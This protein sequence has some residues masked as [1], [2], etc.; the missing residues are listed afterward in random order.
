[1]SGSSGIQ[2]QFFPAHVEGLDTRVWQA[3]GT[4][5]KMAGVVFTRRG[6]VRKTPGIV[7]LTDWGDSSLP[8]GATAIDSMASFYRH[9]ALELVFAYGDKLGVLQGEAV[10]A[11]DSGRTTASRLRDGVR[12][13]QVG[14][15]LIITN[16]RDPNV[17]W[18]GRDLTP[19]G[20]GS[21]PE[22]PVAYLGESAVGG[23]FTNLSWKQGDDD[24]EVEYR[25]TWVNDH[26]QESEASPASNTID[27]SEAT[28]SYRYT[29]L[30]T[31]DTETPSDDVIESNYYRSVDGG[32]W[33]FLQKMRGIRCRTFFDHVAPGFT[34][35]DTLATTGSN[36][37]P[38]LSL[39]T[40]PFRGR[41][42]YRSVENPSLLHYSRLING[43][44]APEAVASTNFIDVAS[45]DGDVVTGWALAQD[46]AVV[47]KRRSMFQLTH[48]K[49]ETPVIA[50]VFTG[51]GA[52]S[53]RAVASL[54]G[55][56]FFLS[57]SGIYV[58][59]GVNV[60]PVSRELNDIVEMLPSAY[61]EDAFAWASVEDRRVYFSVVR[62]GDT[63]RAVF[64]IHVDALEGGPASAFSVIEDFPL[65]CA[66][67][68]KHEVLVGFKSQT[69]GSEKWDLGQWNSSDLVRDTAYSGSWNTK[70][71]DMDSPDKDKIFKYVEVVYVQTGNY[72][73]TLNW[74]S[75]WD[76]RT[77]A[78]TTTFALT[79][80]DA[81]HWDDGNWDTSRSWDGARTRSKR[82]PISDL[83][84]K[85]L[86]LEF[87]TA[88]GS[89]PWKIVGFYVE[90]SDQGKRTRGTDT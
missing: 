32:P 13:T 38:P 51:V 8:F 46:F 18:D 57:E 35:T 3:Q 40:F 52:V 14:D 33:Y 49:T 86:Q 11:I 2:R 72:S 47:F 41:V 76:D 16:G 27:T 73:C 83:V 65:S 50:P 28:S 62:E 61:L 15:I 63:N 20:V 68:Y 19:L 90:W 82:V 44:P 45:G 53:D 9:G 36:L 67:P 4:S 25:R 84:G 87:S 56:V 29:M 69:G 5:S 54:D 34:S 58:F 30:V 70:W 24:H 22:A 85:S 74:Y 10:T 81:L 23:V 55:R 43:T 78:G 7:P 88:S 80:P 77:A 60:V 12:F 64:A 66:L 75:N 71:L 17:K 39:F 31:G 89:T 59:D 1:M 42:Y 37:P 48:D 21:R 6:E 26:G 79:D